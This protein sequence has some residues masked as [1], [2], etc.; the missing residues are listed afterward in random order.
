MK[1]ILLLAPPNNF[2]LNSKLCRISLLYLATA[3]KQSDYQVNIEQISNLSELVSILKVQYDFIG[4]SATT[5]EYPGA[6]SILN[7]IKRLNPSIKVCIGGNHA[8]ALPDECLRNGFDIVV[9]GEAEQIICQLVNEALQP[10]FQPKIVQAGF[11]YNIDSIPIPDRSL[12]KH[13]QFFPSLCGINNKDQKTATILLSR[14]CCYNCSFCG[15]HFPYRRRTIEN[16]VS[17]LA[18]LFDEG[19]NSLILLDDLPFITFS[20]VKEYCNEVTK[21]NFAWRSNF[22]TDLLTS[23]IISMLVKSNCKRI[24]IGVESVDNEQL[25]KLNKLTTNSINEQA[26]FDCRR[27]GLEVKAMFMFGLPEENHVVAAENIISFVKR[28][29]PH[30]VQ[31]SKYATL[32]GSTLWNNG[33]NIDVVDYTKLVFFQN[34]IMNIEEPFEIIYRNLITELR[35][36]TI[37]DDGVPKYQE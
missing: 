5:P 19:F 24:Q 28:T 35:N 31:V 22:R 1:K 14:G 15:I 20:Q 32:P 3:L 2:L 10:N 17:E 9:C 34:D 18:M 37:V 36:Y 13:L 11:I 16:V 23:D 21:Y 30:S 29:K 12:V 27:L 6:L 25:K 8:T 7:Y 33:L 26:I 4:I